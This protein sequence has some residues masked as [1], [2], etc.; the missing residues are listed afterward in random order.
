MEE[1]NRPTCL[2]AEILQ[3]FKAAA[4]LLGEGW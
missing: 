2:G 3:L 4:A 1:T